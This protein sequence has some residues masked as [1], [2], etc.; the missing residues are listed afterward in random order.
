MLWGSIA[1]A[2]VIIA[3]YSRIIRSMEIAV[4]TGANKGIGFEISR[5]LA[6]QGFKTILAARNPDLGKLAATELQKNGL[7]VEFRQLDISDH[8]SVLNF[9][10]KFQDDYGRCDVLVNNAAIAFKGSDP[11]PFTEQAEPTIHTNFFATLDITK[12]MIPLLEQSLCPR[13]VNVASEAG[14]LRILP[15]QLRRDEFTAP[16]LSLEKL[17]ALMRDFVADVKNGRHVERGW[18]N[19]CYGTSKLGV[20]ALSKVLARDHPNMIINACCPGYCQTDMSSQ[21]GN[22]SP[23]EGARTPVM[24]AQAKK[25]SLSGGFFAGEREIEW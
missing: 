7:D 18:P 5:Q 19:T 20:I 12:A 21:R 22:N 14:H 4:V 11:T 9:A 3:F 13:I 24:L 10:S 23:A 2:I 25:G 15:S 17:E 16:D 1:T 6:S 8:D